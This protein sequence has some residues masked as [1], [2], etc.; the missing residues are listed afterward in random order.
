MPDAP[1]SGFFIPPF[2][3]DFFLAAFVLLNVTSGFSQEG[4]GE[5]EKNKAKQTDTIQLPT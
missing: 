5:G 1:I 2:H 4:V 3:S